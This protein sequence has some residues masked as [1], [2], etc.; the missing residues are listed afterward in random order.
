MPAHNDLLLGLLGVTSTIKGYEP[1]ER[2]FLNGLTEGEFRAITA[3]IEGQKDFQAAPEKYRAIINNLQGQ[4]KD[5][6]KNPVFRG[7]IEDVSL[8][9]NA[10]FIEYEPAIRTPVIKYDELFL[11]F[12]INGTYQIPFLGI[13]LGHIALSEPGEFS[14]GLLCKDIRHKSPLD[15]ELQEHLFRFINHNDAIRHSFQS[16]SY[17]ISI[18]EHYL[19]TDGKYQRKSS[20]TLEWKEGQKNKKAEFHQGNLTFSVTAKIQYRFTPAIGTD[21][22]ELEDTFRLRKYSVV[23]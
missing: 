15:T 12:A 17:G 1:D 14:R 21:F 18:L 23:E 9:V 16:H 8:V 10:A 3:E 4:E 2:K 13:N 6:N 5:K 22:P 7:L 19:N 20:F 11:P